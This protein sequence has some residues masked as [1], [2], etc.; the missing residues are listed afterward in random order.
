MTVVA[1][2]G[3]TGFVGRNVARA[4][5]KEGTRW[6]G[7]VRNQ[8]KFAALDLPQGEIVAGSLED[9][10]ALE[11]LCEGTSAVIHCGG[12]IAALSRKDF[13]TTN[14]AGTSLLL[15]ASIRMGVKRFVHVS[16]LAAREPLV[17]DYAASKRAG[18]EA[19]KQGAGSISWVI[20]RP[21]VV[22]GP[23]DAATVPLMRSL[24]RPIAFVPGSAATRLSLIHVEDL[25]RAL[26]MLASNHDIQ[27]TVLEIDDGKA[28]GYNFE[29]IAAAAS[30]ATGA[31]PR[32]VFVPRPM[33]AGPALFSLLMA[34]ATRTP[35]MFCPDKLGELYHRDWVVSPDK[36]EFAGWEPRIDFSTGFADTLRWYKKHDWLPEGVG[37]A[38]RSRQK[39]A[40]Y[41]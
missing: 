32:V 1:V 40:V 37:N 24:A 23:G 22:Y 20:V 41:P 2:T 6:R 21:P 33:L 15:A 18:E 38:G 31:K 12:N 28:G 14:V 29:E 39:G 8:R 16:S 4:L 36:R 19:V 17:S 27:S 34:R 30:Q 25:A 13:F 5:A 26:A 11:R 10:A 3:L 9:T 35:A 7:L